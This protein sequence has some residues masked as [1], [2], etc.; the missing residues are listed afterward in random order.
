MAEHAGQWL[1]EEGMAYWLGL[2]FKKF[3]RK[4]GRLM[5]EASASSG[6]P[7]AV[8]E[9]HCWGWNGMERDWKKAF[10]MCVKIEQETN[11]YHWAQNLLGE[12][13]RYGC[14]TD[15]DVTKAVEWHTKSSEQ[16]HS[17]AM[18]NLGYCYE[19][20]Q[21]CDQ[22]DTKAVEWYEKSANLGCITAMS[23]LG[24]M[25]QYGRGVTKDLTK[26]RE[27]YTKAAAQGC[28]NAQTRLDRLNAANN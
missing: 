3:D 6:F 17:L 2:N 27:W 16:G 21:G 24:T 22:N 8:A 26:A 28:A 9:C 11:G 7:L 10:E 19:H 13:Y 4:R 25:Y 15:Q 5:V 20:G 14:G 12:C 18:N 23:N 1:Y